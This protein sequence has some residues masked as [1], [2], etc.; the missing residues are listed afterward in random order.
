MS[1]L[2][3]LTARPIAHRGYHDL[4]AGRVEN[5]PTAIQAAIDND[6]AIEVDLQETSDGEA[7]VF[8]DFKLDRLARDSGQVIERTSTELCSL[9]MKES[10]DRLW[11]LQDL[12]DLVDGKVP[13]MIEVKSKMLTGAQDAFI[14]RI[15]ALVADYKGPVSIKSFDPDMLSILRHVAPQITRGALADGT[16]NKGEYRR[17]TRI[18]RFAF[19][20]LLHTVR[21]KPDYISYGI[22][23]LPAIA[24][25][26]LRR[27]FGLPVVT[28]TVKTSEHRQRAALYADQ[29]V[30]EGFDPDKQS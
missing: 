22:R 11:L 3:W 24:P 9:A 5:T 12:L 10:E 1:D 15:A 26:F 29:I 7:L 4:D 21:T 30:F 8:H 20:H 6:F 14:R 17:Y 23:D 25:S 18:E 28:W 13:L 16:P 2:S 27:C 19:R